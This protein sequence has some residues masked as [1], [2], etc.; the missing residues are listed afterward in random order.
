M[1][2]DS[3]LDLLV[4]A[5]RRRSAISIATSAGGEANRH[6]QCCIIHDALREGRDLYDVADARTLDSE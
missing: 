1:V 5:R 3:D 6:N 4:V 2:D